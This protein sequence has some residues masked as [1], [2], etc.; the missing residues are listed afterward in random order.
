M[1]EK[2]LEEL[3]QQNEKK[4]RENEALKKKLEELEKQLKKKND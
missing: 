1:D 3:R 2:E 4:D